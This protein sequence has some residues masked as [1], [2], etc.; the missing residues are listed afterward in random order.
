MLGENAVRQ[1]IVGLGGL[2]HLTPDYASELSRT[3][4][5]NLGYLSWQQLIPV[6]AGN[7]GA[8]DL[9][10]YGQLKTNPSMA[11]EQRQSDADGSVWW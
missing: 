1:A 11:V 2:A 5:K 4:A 9:R 8:L 10:T 6:E 3:H 7:V